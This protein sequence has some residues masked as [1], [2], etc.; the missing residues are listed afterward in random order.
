MGNITRVPLSMV[1]PSAGTAGD[2]VVFDGAKLELQEEPV[3]TDKSIKSA[4]FDPTTGT[5][6]IALTDGSQIDVSGFMVP[7][8]IGVGPTGPTGPQGPSGKNGRDG[9]DGRPGEQGCQGVKGDIG[10]AGPAGGY[11]GIGP[12]GPIGPT[13]PQGPQGLPGAKGDTG[14]AG[15]IGPT[16]PIGPSGIQGI[17]GITGPT[18]PI[19]ATGP[20]GATGP[21]GPIGPTGPTGAKGDSITGPMG[22]IGPRGATGPTGIQGL[23]GLA[24]LTLVNKW[25]NTD[26]NVGRYYSVDSDNLS[27]EVFG[28]YRNDVDFQSSVT[29]DYSFNGSGSQVAKLFIQPLEEFANASFPYEYT[30]TDPVNG[31][32]SFTVTSP[33]VKSGWHFN[34]RILLASP[35]G[36]PVI[37]IADTTGM[38]PTDPT[39]DTSMKFAI[40]TDKQF[41]MPVAV[42]WKTK[43]NDAN[44]AAPAIPIT[45]T[46]FAY[47]DLAAGNEFYLAGTP[48]PSSSEVATWSV[49]GTKLNSAIRTGNYVAALSAFDYKEFTVEFTVGS[50]DVGRN[51]VGGILAFARVNNENHYLLA[52]RHQ[53]GLVGTPSFA[54]LYVK[55]NTIQKVVASY[56]DG[57]VTSGWNGTTSVVKMQR[58]GSVVT[59]ATSPFGSAVLDTVNQLS[60]DLT[61]D[62]DLAVFANASPFG[63]YVQGQQASSISNIAFTFPIADYQPEFG[64]ARI[65]AFQNIAYVPITIF[66]GDIANV[67]PRNIQLVLSNPKNASILAPGFA[68]GTY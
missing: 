14:P 33:D 27:V 60:I 62:P 25:I 23:P 45:T 63:F 43:S 9:K 58:S 35:D 20:G 30:L 39:L 8:N 57:L 51:Q 36:Y 7:G 1:A 47:W 3:S 4:S 18:G 40:S 41:D 11:G 22:P 10:P 21:T 65:E 46:D 68:T 50:T 42:S 49:D 26:L 17:Q 24:S 31:V 28:S 55:G 32:G 59:V 37:S 5:L 38:R 48:F 6:T 61:T 53:G 15:G 66:G 44:A 19:G 64:V 16:G 13:G 56:D 54:I 67:N 29:I 52:A 34:W 12:R 2:Q